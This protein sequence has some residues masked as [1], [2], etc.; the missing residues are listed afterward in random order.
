LLF[1]IAW[2]EP[3]GLVIIEAM[4]C[5]TPIIAFRHGS[6]PE[7]LDDGITGLVVGDADE[8]VAAVARIPTLSRARCRRVFEERFSAERMAHDY[9]ELYRRLAQG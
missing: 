3:F 8:A 6:V 9:L 4:A 7:V 2:P 1:P 5:G